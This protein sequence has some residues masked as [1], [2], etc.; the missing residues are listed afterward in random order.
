MLSYCDTSPLKQTL[1]RLVDFDRINSPEIRFSVGAAT[2]A[3][4]TRSTSTHPH[5]LAA[6]AELPVLKIES[7]VHYIADMTLALGTVE[8]DYLA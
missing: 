5:A 3:T 2:C 7:A 6:V 1:E 8:H 4:A